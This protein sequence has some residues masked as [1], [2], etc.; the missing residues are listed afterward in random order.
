MRWKELIAGSVFGAIAT[1]VGIAGAP[2]GAEDY[3]DFFDSAS[4]TDTTI[5]LVYAP[6]DCFA[7]FG[8][9][10]RW[11]RT[12]QYQS[13]NV[14]L[15]LTSKPTAAQKA[16]LAAHGISAYKVVRERNT[17][18][19]RTPATLLYIN[20]QLRAL[21][22]V[23]PGRDVILDWLTG[24]ADATVNPNRVDRAL[25]VSEHVSQF[26]EVRDEGSTSTSIVFPQHAVLV[27]GLLMAA[28]LAG[29]VYA[30]GASPRSSEAAGWEDCWV[31][32][33]GRCKYTCTVAPAECPCEAWPG[34]G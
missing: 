10:S 6:S 28:G 14:H 4:P 26:S 21:S 34:C 5:I 22:F 2:G 31:T 18:V 16:Q 25:T 20:G 33:Q 13:S 1:M 19:A 12:R 7:C 15:V 17:A 11:M 9:L 29:A 23:R 24:S 8:V 32:A 3:I 30:A 27:G